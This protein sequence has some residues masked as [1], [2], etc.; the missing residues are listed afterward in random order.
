MLM[1]FM[2]ELIAGKLQCETVKAILVHVLPELGKGTYFYYAFSKSL[3][4]FGLIQI[5]QMN[6]MS[7][8]LF[9][10]IIDCNGSSKRLIFSKI[11]LLRRLCFY[12]S[13]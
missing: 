7:G 3:Q 11:T 5:V 10:T 9:F 1:N 4:L 12:L 6:T 2:F 8:G 13:L